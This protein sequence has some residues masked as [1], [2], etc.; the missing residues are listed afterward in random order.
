MTTKVLNTWKEL[1]ISSI[2]GRIL[3]INLTIGWKL[4][5]HDAENVASTELQQYILHETGKSNW[6]QITT[7]HENFWIMPTG[8]KLGNNSTSYHT[9]R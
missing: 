3:D 1:D 9:G 5:C 2:K 4:L 6:I 8:K 7:T